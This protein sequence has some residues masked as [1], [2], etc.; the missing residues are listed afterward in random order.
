MGCR[1][2]GLDDWFAQQKYH[3]EIKRYN[4]HNQWDMDRFS[5]N[6]LS[7]Q[8]NSTLVPS[9]CRFIPIDVAS[10]FFWK[11]DL[12]VYHGGYTEAPW[13][14]INYLAFNG[15][16]NFNHPRVREGA[17]VQLYDGALVERS[18]GVDTPFLYGQV[19][20]FIGFDE[21]YVA[22]VLDIW[23]FYRTPGGHPAAYWLEADLPLTT[24]YLTTIIVL[25]GIRHCLLPQT[26]LLEY[27]PGELTE[28]RTGEEH[29]GGCVVMWGPERPWY[30]NKEWRHPAFEGKGEVEWG[31]ISLRAEVRKFGR[32][33]LRIRGAQQ[34]EESWLPH[35][36]R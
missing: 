20:K 6:L 3:Q 19:W 22:A 4:L 7:A 29:P 1:E 8:P 15:F 5:W 25:L 30:K 17:Y 12:V 24:P 13:I 9:A 21:R 33:A 26:Q 32:G 31:D 27:A 36:E 28:Q 18:C 2:A 23:T 34:P 16:S 10:P 35:G 14:K 11:S